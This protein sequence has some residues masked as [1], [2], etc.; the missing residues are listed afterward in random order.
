MI[1]CILL[2][3]IVVAFLLLRWTDRLIFGKDNEKI[4]PDI[5]YCQYPRVAKDMYQ[6]TLFPLE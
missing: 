2:A 3:I 4:L 6:P 5:Y 1:T